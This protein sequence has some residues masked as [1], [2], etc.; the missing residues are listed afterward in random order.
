MSTPP[1]RAL[2]T[3][4]DGTLIPLDGNAQN[5]RDLRALGERLKSGG[6]GLVFVTGRHFSSVQQAMG[7][8]HLPTP[9]AIICDVGTS[10]FEGGGDGRFQPVQAYAQ[11]LGEI[12]APMPIGELRSR[13]ESIEGLRAQEDE[14]QGPFKLSYYADADALPGLA[15]RVQRLLDQWDAPYSLIHSV[16]PFNND[17]LL[18][19]LPR[20]VSKAHAL[21]WWVERCGWDNRDVVFCGD[22]GN[23]LAALT[24]GYNAVVVGNASRKLA[25]QVYDAHRDAGWRNRLC[26]PNAAATSG[27]LAGAGWFGL[28]AFEQTPPEPM[29]ATPVSASKTHF[30]VWAP[31]CKSVSVEIG[32]PGD[33]VRHELTP[34][35]DGCFAG[36]A[37]AAPGDKYSYLLEGPIARPD[38]VSRRQPDGVHGPSEV[39]DPNAFPWTD[40]EWRG[41]AKRD[42][43]IY[44]LHIGS[45]TEEGTFRAAIERLPELVELGATAV[46]VMP[47]AQSPG[48]WNWGYDGVNLYAVTHNY[49]TPDDFRTLVDAC[50]AAGLAVLLDVVYNHLGPEG[51]YLGEFGPYFSRKHH[52][53]WGS[54][55]NYDGRRSDPVRRWVVENALYWLRDL[56]LDGLRLDAVH[57]M[58]DDSEHT[59]LDEI[60]AATLEFEQRSGRAI[61]LI[62]ESNVYDERLL[63]SVGGLKGYDAIWS[64]CLMHSIYTHASPDFK[65]T[66]REYHG[67][68]NLLEAMEHGYLYESSQYVRVAREALGGDLPDRSYIGSL[69][70]ALQTHDA[71]GNHPEGKRLHQLASKDYQ[72]SAAAIMLLYPSIPLLFMGEESAVEAPFPFFADFHD[73]GLR[74]AVDRGRI[75]EYPHHDWSNAPLPS[76]RKSFR[77]SKCADPKLQDPQMR[78][79]YQQLLTLRRHGLAAGWLTPDAMRCEHDTESHVFKLHYSNADG[80]VTVL[81]RLTPNDHD[82]QPIEIELPGEVLMSSLETEV[83]GGQAVLRPNQAVVVGPPAG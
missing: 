58:H 57:F 33:A 24:A 48:K 35:E 27:V 13:L 5:Q 55:V 37:S 50:H 1:R 75:A 80:G 49:G 61:H 32:E 81:A 23:D 78:A 76:E 2:A 18:D 72:R 79:W 47:V 21:D 52:T 41:V 22:S 39:V 51:N 4:L 67:T 9:E 60:R 16:D 29:G 74:R 8:H 42:L 20:G 28:V 17:G 40:A 34:G 63:A 73:R 6:V 59:I 53:P 44:E 25:R 45:F 69:V 10:V 31:K 62:G 71:V 54:A 19:L 46:E 68:H 66:N 14:K 64:D 15:E 26:L 77:I 83:N 82:A 43:V 70:T 7:E 11:H 56:H 30:R 3:D 36:F 65:L 12:I 38:P